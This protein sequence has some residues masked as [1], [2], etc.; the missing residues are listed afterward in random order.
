MSGEI[1][2]W[3]KLKFLSFIIKQLKM[4]LK[5]WTEKSKIQ[6]GA[7]EKALKF[8]EARKLLRSF[9]IIQGSRPKLEPK[10]Q[11]TVADY[12]LFV[13]SRSLWVVDGSLYIP[14]DKASLLHAVEDA[15]VQKDQS[16]LNDLVESVMDTGETGAVQVIVINEMVVL[17]YLK[18]T[19]TVRKI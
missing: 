9:L 12:E 4:K 3:H 6:S 5:T 16:E 18:R 13:V 2:K 15:S 17:Q 19:A 8:S 11:E 10:L 1:G 7:G 14:L